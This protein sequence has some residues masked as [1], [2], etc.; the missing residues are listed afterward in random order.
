[1]YAYQKRELQLASESFF[2]TGSG[3]IE[4]TSTRALNQHNEPQEVFATGEP[5]TIEIGYLAHIPIHNPGSGIGNFSAG[6]GAEV[7]GPNTKLAGVDLGTLSGE[8][9][10]RYEIEQLPLLPATYLVTTAVHDGRS[11][12][13][14]DY[15]KQAYSF[16]M[17]AGS[18]QE[19]EGLVQLP[20]SW[21]QG[22]GLTRHN[23]AHKD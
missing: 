13:C 3:E 21:Q 12:Q 11:H 5:M 17:E 20:A 15:H 6:W 14:Y 7:N 2:R 1:M 4:I 16:R 8:G 18:A 19:L 9:V 10:V 23:A 22:N